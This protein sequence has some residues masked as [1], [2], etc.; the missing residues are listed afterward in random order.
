MK[1][2][3]IVLMLVLTLAVP[4]MTSYA[5]GVGGVD[6]PWGDIANWL[7]DYPG[8][9]EGIWQNRDAGSFYYVLPDG[10]D[11]KNNYIDGV[12]ISWTGEAS[13]PLHSNTSTTLNYV[14]QS[15][16]YGGKMPY[17]QFLDANFSNP[18]KLPLMPSDFSLSA[19][20]EYHAGNYPELDY[21][22]EAYDW[23][24]AQMPVLMQLSETERAKKMA[25]L[26][27][28]KLTYTVTSDCGAV[29]FHTGQA[30]E[31][32]F[33]S[34]YNEFL[35]RAGLGNYASIWGNK[36]YHPRPNDRWNV[37]YADGKVYFVDI[38]SY[39]E[40]GDEKFLF[41]DDEHQWQ[42]CVTEEE[43]EARRAADIRH[44]EEVKAELK[45]IHPGPIGGTPIDGETGGAI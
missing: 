30:G 5:N 45:R 16:F 11:L 14:M 8:R 9:I 36:P 17:N 33:S 12:Y 31:N 27:A 3:I 40:T 2:S 20:A 39:K 35:I 4:T 7:N 15:A 10:S 44:G 18:D 24:D 34:L 13:R 43:V 37:F 21:L 26:L 19:L 6:S 23:M 1:K 42:G 22:K 41:N 29:C 32:G 38:T 28:E 25:L